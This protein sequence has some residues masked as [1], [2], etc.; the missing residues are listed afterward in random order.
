LR[1]IH[2]KINAV[3]N[4][5]PP[6]G[7]LLSSLR[8]HSVEIGPQSDFTAPAAHRIYEGSQHLNLLSRTRR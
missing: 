3:Q 2:L 4:K 8:K 5:C 1:A 6:R 7:R